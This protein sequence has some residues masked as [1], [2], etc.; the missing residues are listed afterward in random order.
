M[1]NKA[2]FNAFFTWGRN[3]RATARADRY[4]L[5]RDHLRLLELPEKPKL[6]LDGTIFVMQACVAYA[7]L[8]GQPIEGLLA[9]Q[10]YDPGESGDVP[11][12]ATFNLCSVDIAPH[13]N[14][15]VS[16]KTNGRYIA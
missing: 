9:M 12:I 13:S 16:G 10:A 8:D 14:G 5:F 4:T 6:M 2:R 3:F 15:I 7:S 11:Y 1:P